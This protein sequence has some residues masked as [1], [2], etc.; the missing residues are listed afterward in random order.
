MVAELLYLEK[1]GGSLPIEMLINSS[2]TTRQDGEIVSLLLGRGGMGCGR[3]RQRSIVLPLGEKKTRCNTGGGGGA[4]GPWRRKRSF[5]CSHADPK[6]DHHL[7]HHHPPPPPNQHHS[8][9][10]QLAFDSE[11]IALTSTMGFVRNPISTVNMGLAVGWSAAV[12]AFG[13]KGW[14]KSLPHSLAMIQQ[15]RVPPTGQ[16]Q[17]IEVHIKWR[18]VLDFKRELLRVLSIGTGWDVHKLDCDMQR[19]LYMR[20]ADALEYGIIDEVIQPDA[21]KASA[22]AQYWL[23]SGRAESEG[24]LEQWKEYIDRQEVLNMKESFRKVRAQQLRDS[25]RD[26]AAKATPKEAVTA[27]LGKLRSAL[28]PAALVDG[29]DSMRLPFSREGLKMALLNAERYAPRSVARQAAAGRADLPSGWR[30]EIDAMRP[31]ARVRQE[32]ASPFVS[33]EVDYSAL[34]AAVDAMAPED[35]AALDLDK[36]ALKYAK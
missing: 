24:R 5:S 17:A 2:G 13:K 35:F 9:N 22:A 20:P 16:R 4:G 8:I 36:L 29:G 34:V 23:R 6:T 19:P 10:K 27:R 32:A 3:E 15:P 14:R 25:Y 28:P 26:A 18:E 7:H 21:A 11:G 1:Q 31:E 12:L 33:K 30:A